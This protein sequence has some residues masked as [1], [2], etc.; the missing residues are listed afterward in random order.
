MSEE[1][2]KVD[3]NSTEELFE[4][5]SIKADKGQAP[6]RIDKFLMDRMEKVTRNRVQ[7]GISQGLVRVNGKIVKSNYKVRPH[8]EIKV[9]L[10]DVPRELKLIPEPIDFGVVYEDD[11]VLVIEKPAGLVVHPG[12]GNYRGTLVNGLVHY[13]KDSELP[14]KQGND[15]SRPGLVHRIDKETSGLMIIAKTIEAMTSLSEQFFHH[16]IDREYVAMVWS[17]PKEEKGTIE[18]LIGRHPNNRMLMAVSEEEDFGKRAVTH[19][20]VIE[21]LY[22]VSLVKCQLETG[23]THQIRV[24]MKH[25]GHPLFN[26]KRYG[27]DM[28]RKGTVYTK[29]KQFVHNCFEM[30]PRQALHARVLGFEHPTT[31]ER[32]RFESPLPE[33][34]ASVVDKWRHY[35]E[36]KKI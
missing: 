9:Y 10:D 24:H 36:H 11:Q 3:D 5:Y 35:L 4:F 30:L 34:F 17:C 25:L 31:G 32:M 13:F 26:D 7:T 20:E 21:D 16:T 8:D 2:E 19:Y 22:Y 12:V 15:V 6:L 14:I 23:R 27:G 28:I 29:Y 1:V 33:D 18:N